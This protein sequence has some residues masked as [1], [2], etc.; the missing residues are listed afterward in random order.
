MLAK[1]IEKEIGVKYYDGVPTTEQ[2]VEEYEVESE[3]KDDTIL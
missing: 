3:V 2:E 1:A